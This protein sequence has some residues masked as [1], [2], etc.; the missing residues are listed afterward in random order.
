MVWKVPRRTLHSCTIV[1]SSP[2]P[3]PV[4]FFRTAH[5]SFLPS[6]WSPLPSLL[7]SPRWSEMFAS[8]LSTEFSSWVCWHV[9]LPMRLY[10]RSTSCDSTLF[11]SSV[12]KALTWRGW[13]LWSLSPSLVFI[14]DFL[15]V[16]HVCSPKFE[17]QHRDLAIC[18]CQLGYSIVNHIQGGPKKIRQISDHRQ[19]FNVHQSLRGH[20]GPWVA[21]H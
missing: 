11:V 13:L 5:R 9:H 16:A 20:S 6:V 2:S 15:L 12:I 8:T 17:V 3:S 7:S 18:A 4:P 21:F 10:I 14:H 1:I 19:R